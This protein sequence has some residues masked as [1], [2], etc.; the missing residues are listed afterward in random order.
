MEPYLYLIAISGGFFAGVLN[1]LAGNG[2]AITLSILTLIFNLPEDIANGTNRLGVLF[3][4]ITSTWSFY[5]NDKLQLNRAY[6]IIIPCLLGALAGAWAAITI[7]NEQFKVIFKFLMVLM[8]FI[9]L[10]KPKRWLRK[11]DFENPPSL[12]ITIPAFLL[13]GFYGGF[14]QMGMGIFFLAIMVLLAKY[15]ISDANGIKAFVILVYTS[16]VICIFAWHGLIDWKIGGLIASGQAIGGLVGGK[17]ATQ[18]PKADIWAHRLLVLVVIVV[19]IQLF[20]VGN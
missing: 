1:T 19:L 9:I 8:F 4:G 3:Q 7:S 17:F 15:S 12:W 6:P 14:I 16:I 5:A 11:T 10:I 18:H 20:I 2:S 13:L